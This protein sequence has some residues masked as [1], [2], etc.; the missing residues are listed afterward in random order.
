MTSHELAKFLLGLP[1]LPIATHANDH[2]YFSQNLA[3][4]IKIALA[5][6]YMGDC[7]MIG[8]MLKMNLNSPNY[9]LKKV[10]YGNKLPINSPLTINNQWEFGEEVEEFLPPEKE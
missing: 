8:N 5:H 6:S 4:P 10:L 7:I 1:E 9:F 3:S 2:S